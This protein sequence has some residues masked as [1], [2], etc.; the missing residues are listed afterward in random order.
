MDLWK[1]CISFLC[2]QINLWFSYFGTFLSTWSLSYVQLINCHFYLFWSSAFSFSSQYLLLLFKSRSCVF[3][4]TPFNSVIC[5]SMALWRRQFVLRIW[6]IQLAF[7]CRILF[8]S[9]LFSPVRVHSRTSSLVIFSDH[10][11]FSILFQHHI[12]KLSKYFCSNFVSVQVSEPY[13]NI[14]MWLQVMFLLTDTGPSL[15]ECV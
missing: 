8:R 12:S 9:V 10:F 13:R 5:S 7:L 14:Y 11:I 6:P 1:I 2:S 15:I 3:L 4:L